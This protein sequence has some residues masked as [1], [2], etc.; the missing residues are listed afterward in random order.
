MLSNLWHK[1]ETFFVVTVI[2]LL[3]WLYAEG[4]N[5][6][7]YTRSVTVRFV[8]PLGQ[9][10]AIQ[11]SG[12]QPLRLTYSS[13][14]SQDQRFR[15]VAARPIDLEIDLEAGV[16]RAEQSVSVRER[17]MSEPRIVSFGLQIESIEPD[18]P[19]TVTAE[20]LTAV[21]LP[22]AIAP[23]AVQ[24]EPGYAIDPSE[25]RIQLPVHWA[26]A[27]KDLQLQ[28]ELDQIAESLEPG[29]PYSKRL[30]ISPPPGLEQY[31][32][33][34]PDR[35]LVT[36]TVKSQ[37]Q[38]VTLEGVK[39]LLML[40]PLLARQYDVA[41][42]N[43][44]LVLDPIE[45]VG[46]SNKIAA[47][48]ADPQQVVAVLRLTADELATAITAKQ[49]QLSLPEGVRTVEPPPRLEIVVTVRQPASGGG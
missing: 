24:L 46:P 14:T 13:S 15:A 41:L 1:L 49:V 2:T 39:I 38:A 40:P 6:Q 11:P 47:I 19:I 23:G 36:F 32:R 8:P 30:R 3:I 37:T 18:Q 10:L 44:Q 43:E 34:E 33:V 22:I 31:A 5:V 26:M 7:R 29:Q 28:V 16:D 42:A 12:P 4:E 27:S 25:A 45:I 35:T 21:T 17:L 20:R 48:K 9:S